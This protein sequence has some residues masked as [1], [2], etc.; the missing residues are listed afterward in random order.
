MDVFTLFPGQGAQRAGMLQGFAADPEVRALVAQAEAVL[1]LPLGRWMLEGPEEALKPTEIAQPA[2]LTLGVAAAR[3]LVRSGVRVV[4]AAGHSLGEITALAAAGA[5]DFSDAVRLVHLRGKAMQAATAGGDTTMVAVLGLDEAAVA[6]TVAAGAA[7]GVVAAA[8]FNA[9]GH[10]VLSGER[11]AVAAAVEAARAAGARR[12]IELE[13]S[14]A[15]HSPL[16]AP[17]AE[18]LAAVLA[19]MEVRAPAYPVWSN[20]RLAPHEPDPEA[21]RRDLVA[22]ITAPVRWS[23]QVRRMQAPVRAV[24]L[25]PAGVL[26]G[27]I[28][29]IAPQWDVREL[30]RAADLA[31]VLA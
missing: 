7:H 10:V 27:L 13:V 20:A 17:A 12:V 9:P 26:C 19:T 1:D 21:I 6:D 30:A 24:E 16:M 25:A 14:A 5:L 3:V 8:N 18:A 15:F 11:I 22:Q 2:L 28:R 29:R 23:E 31:A 4:G